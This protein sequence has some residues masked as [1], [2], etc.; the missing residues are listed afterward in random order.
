MFKLFLAVAV[1]VAAPVLAQVRVVES[2]PRGI[3]S[4]VAQPQYSESANSDVY[5]Q[6]R[7]LQ[8]EIATLRGMLEEQTHEINKLK[9]LQLDNYM[10]LDRRLSSNSRPV[11]QADNSLTTSSAD[12]SLDS[13]SSDPVAVVEDNR[14]E[15]EVY[16]AAYD[17]LNQR[18]YDAATQEFTSYLNRF[19]QGQFASNSCYWL[20]KIAN[21]SGD[22][23][24]AKSW[25]AKLISDYPDASKV[26]DAK[27][28][29]GRVYFNLGDKIKAKAIMQDVAGG[30]SDAARLATKFLRDNF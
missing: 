23:D 24:Q 12:S 20:G 14:T 26:P 13:I 27:Y 9:Q 22:L 1:F 30:S 5:S 18:D 2:S 16:T 11:D 19:P 8:D 10:E 25:F 7:A 15:K 17:L 3:N 29:L 21:Q 28:D 4:G 6:I